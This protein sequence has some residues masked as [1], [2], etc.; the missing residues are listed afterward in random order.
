MSTTH[1]AISLYRSI[2]REHRRRL[3]ANM[4]EL[5][6]SYVRSEFRL[7]K[8]A[9]D[10]HIEP[11]LEAWDKYLIMLKSRTTVGGRVGS[12]LPDDAKYALSEEQKTKLVELRNEAI[13]AA[14]EKPIDP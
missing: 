5:G 2:L 10:I 14:A 12:D 7:H 3:P 11:F 1:R 13:K 6:N 9:K 4:R 8:T